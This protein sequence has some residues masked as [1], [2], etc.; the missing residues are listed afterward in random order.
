MSVMLLVVVIAWASA[1]ASVSVLVLSAQRK[2]NP[3]AVDWFPRAF[4]EQVALSVEARSDE[5]ADDTVGP[6]SVA[7]EQVVAFVARPVAAPRRHL[8][9]A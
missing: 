2:P 4:A 7:L 6:G 8:L 1:V 3:W 9:A 5:D